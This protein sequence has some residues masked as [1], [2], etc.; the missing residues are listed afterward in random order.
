[1]KEFEGRSAVITGAASGI[2]YA[3]AKKFAE[4]KMNVVLADIEQDALDAAVNKISDLGVEAIGI[5]VDVMDKQAVSHLADESIKAFGNIHVLCNNAGVASTVV[6]DGIWDLDDSDWEWVLGVNFYGT[7]YGIQAF[8][9]HMIKHKEEGHVLNT[10]SLAGILPGEAI[11]GVSKH[12]ALALSESLWQGL[13]KKK[14]KIGA[15][16]LCPGFVATNII[17]SDRNRPDHLAAKNKANFV[18]KKL[19]ATVL[20]RGKE[21]NEIA[22]VTLQAIRDNQF[23][24]LPH[25]NYDD[26]IKERYSRILA[27]TEP[28]EADMQEVLLGT[29][30]SDKGEW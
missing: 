9:P 14:S 30:M 18:L 24:I 12:A 19:A 4:E 2:G 20:K 5:Q 7:L 6:G 8:V 25:T 16:V 22:Q 1:M 29:L 28:Q 17:E 11:Y 10:I 13:K 15:S 3:L 26:M 27:R 23:Y 21:P